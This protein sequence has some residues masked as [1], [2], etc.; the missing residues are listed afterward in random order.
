[1]LSI[2]SVLFNLFFLVVF[3]PKAIHLAHVA[4]SGEGSNLVIS[5]ES[6][7]VAELVLGEQHFQLDAAFVG[8]AT[9]DLIEGATAM[10]VVDDVTAD[11]VV[12][13]PSTQCR[14]VCGY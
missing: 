7:Q 2:V 14:H 10:E 8:I 1:M 13:S 4:G 5:E 11:T 3:G 12:V 9:Y 6:H